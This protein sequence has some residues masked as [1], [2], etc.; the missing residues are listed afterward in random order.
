MTLAQLH[1]ELDAYV[2]SGA[3]AAELDHRVAYRTESDLGAPPPALADY[4]E[5]ALVPA[6]SGWGFEGSGKSCLASSTSSRARF[7]LKREAPAYCSSRFLRRRSFRAA[8]SS[9]PR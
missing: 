8:R 3:F 6:L 1:S 7:N 5:H 9:R 4:L 2:D